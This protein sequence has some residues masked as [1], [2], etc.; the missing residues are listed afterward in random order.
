MSGKMKQWKKRKKKRN[1]RTRKEQTENIGFTPKENK[2]TTKGAYRSPVT[3]GL[4]T[5]HFWCIH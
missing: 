3:A 1:K 4:P 5:S 2:R